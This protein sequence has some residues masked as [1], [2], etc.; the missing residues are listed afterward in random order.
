MTKV[1]G[2]FTTN[3]T[4][5]GLHFSNLPILLKIQQILAMLLKIQ[6]FTK[7]PGMIWGLP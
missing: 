3:P 7:V 5:L 1:V 6:L 4:K 2:Y